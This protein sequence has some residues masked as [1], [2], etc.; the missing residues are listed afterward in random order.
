M[1]TIDKN[2][3]NC[4]PETCCCNSWM[5]LKD[6][7]KFITIQDKNK[8]Q[9]IIDALNNI[10]NDDIKPNIIREEK[11]RS[12]SYVNQDYDKVRITIDM[13]SHILKR[14]KKILNITDTTKPFLYCSKNVLNKLREGD[15]DRYCDGPYGN[16]V[17]EE[18]LS[19]CTNAFT[20]RRELALAIGEY[21]LKLSDI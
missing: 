18:C 11:F 8:A 5:I 2:K 13:D 1:Y 14:F 16:G 17:H 9:T 12:T 6:G 21:V 7:K 10:S 15:K 3:C 4:H 20:D 19:E